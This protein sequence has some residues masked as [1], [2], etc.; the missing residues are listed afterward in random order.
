M[1]LQC[2]INV[3]HTFFFI[4]FN[5]GSYLVAGTQ[6][7][8]Q[9]QDTANTVLATASGVDIA[10]EAQASIDITWTPTTAG[11]IGI[12][13]LSYMPKIKILMM[14]PLLLST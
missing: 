10:S 5:Q 14:T 6:Y 2:I 11:T 3:P 13:G 12:K 8:V 7:T 4:I 1:L 9:L